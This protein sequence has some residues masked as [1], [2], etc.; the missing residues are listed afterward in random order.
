M[1]NVA[2]RTLIRSSPLFRDLPVDT[3][4]S[5]EALAVRRVYHKQRIVFQQGAAGDALY[6]VASGRVLIA[7]NAPDGR[8]I[9]LNIMEPGDVFGEIALLDGGKRT[10]TA[11]TLEESQLIVIDRRRFTALVRR[12][13]SVAL[14]LLQLL[15]K[16][17][18]WTSEVIEE[19][20]LLSV[21]A[22]LARRLVTLARIDGRP[23]VGG[24]ELR[25]SQADLAAFLGISR[26]VVNQH[27]Q[28]WR[29]EGLL[30]LKRARTVIRGERA[31]QALLAE[32]RK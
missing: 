5:V 27:L 21:R 16:R 28:Q 32:R 11:T 13:P 19:A 1:S 20:A 24:T 17:L 23:V 4:A 8:Q 14:Q 2:A 26:Q 9:S 6:G 30:D 7:A 18:R 25:I 15:C 31:V 22:Q 10:A 29:R 3:L 12:E